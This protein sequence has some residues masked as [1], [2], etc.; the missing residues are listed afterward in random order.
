LI[1]VVTLNATN[2][3]GRA[4]T[5][6]LSS[7]EATFV[8]GIFSDTANATSAAAA[9]A[10]ASAAASAV[11][12]AQPFQMPG[13]TI[14]IFPIG[15]I[16]TGVWA[17]LGVGTVTYGTIGRIQFRELYRRRVARVE[18]KGLFT[19]WLLVGWETAEMGPSFYDTNL[20]SA[21]LMDKGW[22]Y[23]YAHVEGVDEGILELVDIGQ[24]AIAAVSNDFIR[25]SSSINALRDWWTTWTS[26]VK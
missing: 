6:T 14:A 3:A 25:Y 19:I 17:L 21:L 12:A 23:S 26:T 10:S 1:P 4:V 15:A 9:A 16:I 5:A 18:N 8:S 20:D 24:G 11:A 7:D 22:L 13:T 2:S